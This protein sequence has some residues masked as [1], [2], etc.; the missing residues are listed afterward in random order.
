MKRKNPMLMSA[1]TA[2]I[3][4]AMRSGIWR[5]NAATA[6]LHAA[7]IKLHSSSEPSWPPHTPAMR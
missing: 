6:P 1:S 7:K 2:K 5:V 4:A 3:R